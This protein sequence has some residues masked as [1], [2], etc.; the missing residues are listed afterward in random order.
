MTITIHSRNEMIRLSARPT[1]SKGK[2]SYLST[3]KFEIQPSSDGLLLSAT[4]TEVTGSGENGGLIRPINR[5][6][7]LELTPH[8]LERLFKAALA[9][10]LLEMTIT[11]RSAKPPNRHTDSI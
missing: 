6:L 2:A 5:K 11:V 4:E 9:A 7:T 8:D 1:K 10:N 3:A